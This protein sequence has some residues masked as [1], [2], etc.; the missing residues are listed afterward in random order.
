ML[1]KE[2]IKQA[3]VE[4]VAKFTGEIFTQVMNQINESTGYLN[5][6]EKVM[7]AVLLGDTISCACKDTIG[8]ESVKN[9]FEHFA[10]EKEKLENERKNDNQEKRGVRSI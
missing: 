10:S 2:H 3:S 7:C 4:K 8:S 9:I 5:D 6:T 1:K